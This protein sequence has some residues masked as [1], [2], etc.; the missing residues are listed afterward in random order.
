L[1][2]PNDKGN[3]GTSLHEVV[4]LVVGVLHDIHSLHNLRVQNKMQAYSTWELD[5]ENG[6]APGEAEAFFF[7]SKHHGVQHAGKHAVLQEEKH[8][9]VEQILAQ[10]V[11][12]QQKLLLVH[13]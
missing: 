9:A 10:D 1:N 2:E 6:V 7:L 13:F 8:Q 4:R 11:G 12:R 3:L 5:N